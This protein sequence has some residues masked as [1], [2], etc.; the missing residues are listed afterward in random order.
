VL[1]IRFTTVSVLFWKRC[2]INEVEIPI[3]I[4]KYRSMK[5]RDYER[6]MMKVLPVK[7]LINCIGI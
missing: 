5:F 1:E 7:T 4:A 3:S 6:K 2:R